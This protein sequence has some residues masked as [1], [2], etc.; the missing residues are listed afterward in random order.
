LD[1]RPQA[2]PIGAET[3]WI[4][5]LK[6]A[7]AAPHPEESAAIAKALAGDSQTFEQIV[8]RHQRR[9]VNLAWRLLGDGDAAKDAAQDVFLRAFKYLHRYETDKPLEAWLVRIALNVC[10]DIRRRRRREA[11]PIEVEASRPPADPHSGLAI[12]ERR[13]MLNRALGVLLERE[14]TALVLRDLEGLSTKETAA[15]LGVSQTAVRALI[16]RARVKIRVAFARM[17]GGSR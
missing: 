5:G 9:I 13:R 15:M 4:D 2:V 1:T 8:V 12:E 17:E 6:S 7:K 14:R 16:G 11:A 3:L 10:S